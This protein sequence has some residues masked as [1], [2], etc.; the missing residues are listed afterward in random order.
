MPSAWQCGEFHKPT[1][2]SG[3]QYLFLNY[4][5]T[6]LALSD[7]RILSLS[8]SRLVTRLGDPALTERIISS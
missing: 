1:D 2:I 6:T 8:W 5:D 3:G 7:Q 4:E